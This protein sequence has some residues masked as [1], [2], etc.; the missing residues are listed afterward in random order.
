MADTER[1]WKNNRKD[2]TLVKPVKKFQEKQH[3]RVETEESKR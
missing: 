1:V 3:K 2:N